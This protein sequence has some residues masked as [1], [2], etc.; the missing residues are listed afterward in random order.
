MTYKTIFSQKAHFY[1]H[2]R[3]SYPVPVFEYLANLL[4]PG[5]KIVEFGCGTGIFTKDLLKYDYEIY[6]VDPCAEMLAECKVELNNNNK[7]TF[8]ES[9]AEDVILKKGSIDAF[10]FPQSLHWM[11]IEKI[12]EIIADAANYNSQIITVWNSRDD[13]NTNCSKKYN[14]I[15]HNYKKRHPLSIHV[16][17]DSY[18]LLNRLYGEGNYKIFKCRHTHQLTQQG[19]EY[20]FLSTSDIDLNAFELSAKQELNSWFNEYQ[21][22]GYVPIQYECFMSVARNQ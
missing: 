11:D 1:K 7:V 12:K 9:S 21:V 16:E 18:I 13:S 4:K 8:I 22:N 14:Q 19:V 2:A 3:P 5:S 6:A 17:T 15:I 10:V 20:L